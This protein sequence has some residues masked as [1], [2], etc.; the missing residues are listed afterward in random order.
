M[1][2]RAVNL[3]LLCWLSMAF[4][5]PPSRIFSSSLR[6][7]ETRSA[8]KRMLASKRGVVGSTRVASTL[9]PSNGLGST[10]SAMGE[11]SETTYRI[12]VQHEGANGS[13]RRTG[14][15]TPR[16]TSHRVVT[17]DLVRGRCASSCN[18]K[19]GLLRGPGDDRFQR[20]LSVDY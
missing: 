1:R 5:P 11:E 9:E 20:F 7:C 16:K 8:R 17:R 19:P 15:E 3:P 6:T 18:R 13:I 12:S 10:R 14:A 2:S 4:W